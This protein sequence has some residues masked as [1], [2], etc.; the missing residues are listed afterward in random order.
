M[1]LRIVAIFGFCICGLGTRARAEQTRYDWR[2]ED[3]LEYDTNPARTEHIAG[4]DLQPAS[5]ASLLARL[6]ASGSL[7]APLGE[8][9][10]LAVS[11]ALGGKWYADS[12]ARAETRSWYKARPLIACALASA[13]RRYSPARTTMSPARSFDLPDFRSTAPS[14]RLTRAW[15]NTSLLPRR[16]RPLV[17]LQARERL[18]LRGPTAFVAIRDAAGDLPAGDAHL[19]WSAEELKVRDFDGR[20]ARPR[21]AAM[22]PASRAT[23]IDF[24]SARGTESTESWLLGGARPCTSTS[25]IAT[26]KRWC[27]VCFTYVPSSP[28]P[29]ICQ[30]WVRG[31]IVATR[32]TDP[33]TF[34]QPVVG[35]PSASIEDESRA[36]SASIWD[37]LS[38]GDSSW[39][40]LCH[41]TSAP[42]S[43]ALEFRCQTLLLYLAFLDES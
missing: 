5:P 7:S 33:L 29:G 14:L 21:A 37:A 27:A 43:G 22:R 31:E 39:W 2:I 8:S 25:R 41:Y 17:H 11:G 1:R 15:A 13:H 24:G 23:A 34:A 20:R 12:G 18:Q 38:R 26:G 10:V 28:C 19:E 35:L 40:T 4:G 42:A 9:N 32:Y 30:L 36:P 6:V 3:G 16:R